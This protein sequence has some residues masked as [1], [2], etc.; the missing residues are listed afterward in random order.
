MKN[1]ALLLILVVFCLSGCLNINPHEDSTSFSFGSNQKTI[2]N[3]SIDDAMMEASN[4]LKFKGVPIDGTLEE[5][6]AR[7]KRKGF[8]SI[9][10][11][12]G[13]AILQGDFAS[14]KK[15]TVYV[16]TLDNKD[17][18]SWINVE[19]PA[20]DQWE[21]LIGDYNGL[22]ELLKEKYGKPSLITEKF[23]NSYINDDADRMYAVKLDRCKYET[24]FNTGNGEILLW[25]EHDKLLSCFV[26]LAYKD[27]INGQIIK[28]VALED[29]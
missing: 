7:M 20:R 11:R 8:K 25:I 10:L 21:Y 6:V 19:F 17:L 13:K 22:K 29:L 3:D 16:S 9:G 26:M 27:K 24:R 5:F 28:D 18:V 14:Y 23:Q 12:N 1:S 2:S 4:H 15:C